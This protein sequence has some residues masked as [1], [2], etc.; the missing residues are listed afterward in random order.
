MPM[1]A[2]GFFSTRAG[3]RKAEKKTVRWTVFPP[4]ESPSKSRRIQYGCGL[5]LRKRKVM[6][7]PKGY[8]NFFARNG[9]RKN[10]TSLQAGAT[11][12]GCFCP[13][14]IIYFPAI[15]RREGKCCFLTKIVRRTG[16]FPRQCAHWLGM[17]LLFAKRMHMPLTHVL[18]GCIIGV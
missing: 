1:W 14:G 9:S 6:G 7:Y 4:W 2:S 12:V 11:Q 5:V 10:G 16:G 3:T 15:S 8:P 17:T 18:L 13:L